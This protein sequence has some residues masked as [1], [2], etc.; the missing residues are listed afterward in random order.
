M[1]EVNSEH[2]FKS[3]DFNSE[4]VFMHFQTEN[5]LKI[6]PKLQL[7]QVIYFYYVD[8]K[9]LHWLHYIPT[10]SLKVYTQ[11]FLLNPA[12]IIPIKAK[13]VKWGRGNF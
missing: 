8:D 12:D 1:T 9:Q 11:I 7:L 13:S 6:N 2:N 10:Q 4:V 3:R 5:T